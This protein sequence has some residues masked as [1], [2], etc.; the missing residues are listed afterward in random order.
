MHYINTKII[1]QHCKSEELYN[2][3]DSRTPNMKQKI[4]NSKKGEINEYK[5]KYM[6][7]KQ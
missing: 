6:Q 5:V 1:H 3:A 2:F 4:Y 7:Q